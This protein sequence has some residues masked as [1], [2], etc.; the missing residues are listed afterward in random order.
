MQRGTESET[1][2][3]AS[4]QSKQQTENHTSRITYRESHSEHHTSRIIERESQSAHHTGTETCSRKE[5]HHI[6]HKRLSALQ[7]A[8]TFPTTKYQ[9]KPSP[10]VVSGLPRTPATV[11][12]MPLDRLATPGKY[13]SWMRTHFGWRGGYQ[14]LGGGVDKRACGRSA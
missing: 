8:N 6:L 10:T 9:H 5:R 13:S 12:V 14:E 2:K 1:L 3:P 7:H 4:K 11:A